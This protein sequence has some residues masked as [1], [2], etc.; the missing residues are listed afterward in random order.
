MIK[1]ENLKKSFDGKTV[2]DGFCLELPDSGAFALSGPS[3]VGKTTLLRIISGLDKD[4]TVQ[5]AITCNDR[6]GMLT[7]LLAVTS[8]MKVNI[9]S[10]NAKPNRSNKTST[11]VMG[12]EVK[13]AQQVAQIMT[14]FRRVKDVY[15]V[16]RS[17]PTATTREPREAEEKE[18]E[19]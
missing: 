7:D 16:S 2:F 14:K 4:Y 5:L 11:V 18:G 10:I 17:M 9:S 13:N 3:G 8:E 1:A 15:S 19:E 6:S 12:L